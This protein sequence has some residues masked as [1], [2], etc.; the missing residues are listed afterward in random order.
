MEREALAAWA[1]R[2]LE[3]RFEN[4]DLLQ[5]AVTHPSFAHE[6]GD[7]AA[8]NQRLEFL[9]DA[10]L[11]VVAAHLVYQEFP[12]WP[13]GR[14]TKLKN[15]LVSAPV[16]AKRALSVG[17]GQ[18]LRLGRGEIRTGGAV[19]ESN[20][21]DAFEALVG[22]LYLDGGLAPAQRFLLKQ[23][24]LEIGPAV[25]GRLAPNHKAA[26][27]ELAQA[28]HLG[29]PTYHVQQVEGPDHQ[30]E[31]RVAVQV[32]GVLEAEGRGA[33]KKA[34]EQEAARCALARFADL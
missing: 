12:R 20:L 32:G 23:L 30:P 29:L 27:L 33:S 16:L 17:I 14:L 13:E 25:S 1:A 24:R 22:A 31:F 5:Q 34:A 3:H 7:L 9:G 21:A 10:V 28:R 26:L 11:G 4:A 15:T 8:S 6:A 19:R 18:W 2:E